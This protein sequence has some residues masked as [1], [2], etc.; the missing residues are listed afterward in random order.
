MMVG[1]LYF[2]VFLLSSSGLDL[3][4]RKITASNWETTNSQVVLLLYKLGRLTGLLTHVP[5][6]SSNLSENA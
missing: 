2:L 4:Q 1:L 6:V 5:G 3:K